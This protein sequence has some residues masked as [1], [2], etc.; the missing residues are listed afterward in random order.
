MHV[1]LFLLTEAE[2][3]PRAS[4]LILQ[5]RNPSTVK[6]PPGCHARGDAAAARSRARWVSVGSWT[7]GARHRRGGGAGG[8]SELG[9]V[10]GNEWVTSEL[11]RLSEGTPD[12]TPRGRSDGRA[13]ARLRPRP[14]TCVTATRRVPAGRFPAGRC[15]APQ[16]T[17]PCATRPGLILLLSLRMPQVTDQL[18]ELQIRSPRTDPDVTPARRHGGRGWSPDVARGTSEAHCNQPTDHVVSSCCS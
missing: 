8:E 16:P 13:E 4:H 7:R 12:G 14:D 11:P 15:A 18:T 3:S 2:F 17:G 6:V 10:G 1:T 5:T 9:R